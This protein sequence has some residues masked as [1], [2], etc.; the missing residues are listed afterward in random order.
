MELYPD[1][2]AA[3]ENICSFEYMGRWEMG[4]CFKKKKKQ[5]DKHSE[6]LNETL[7]SIDL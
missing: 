7:Q 6:L 5:I 1:L 3:P 2:R 4:R